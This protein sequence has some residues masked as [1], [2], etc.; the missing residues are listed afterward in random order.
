MIGGEIDSF[1]V[2]E[3]WRGGQ[4]CHQAKQTVFGDKLHNGFPNFSLGGSANHQA[5]IQCIQHHNEEQKKTNDH[6]QHL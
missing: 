2:D 5:H 4:R 1:V 6:I 3:G